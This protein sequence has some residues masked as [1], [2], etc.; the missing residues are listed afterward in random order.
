MCWNLMSVRHLIQERFCERWDGSP[1]AGVPVTLSPYSIGDRIQVTCRKLK[2]R[3]S[4]A[5][6]ILG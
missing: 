2:D 6:A 1:S 5:T 3:L 4:T